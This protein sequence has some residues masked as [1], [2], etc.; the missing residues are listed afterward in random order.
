[1]SINSQV[2]F[3]LAFLLVT[4]VVFSQVQLLEQGYSGLSVRG[5]GQY[6]PDIMTGTVGLEYNIEGRFTV[7]GLYG[8]V[9]EDTIFNSNADGLK[10]NSKVFGGYGVLEIIEPDKVFPLSLAFI[11][12]YSYYTGTGESGGLIVKSHNVSQIGGGPQ[13][14]S[15][16]FVGTN[17]K[18]AP[19]AEYKFSYVNIARR[20]VPKETELW[21]DIGIALPYSHMVWAEKIG[22]FVDPRFYVRIGA[23]DELH[24]FSNFNV[25]VLFQLPAY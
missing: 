9:V 10:V 24:F 15:R 22:I 1:M 5:G 3:W 16:F 12:D 2:K 11:T 19:F 18:F 7:G 14:G 23:G 17:G 21:H 25:G 8:Q 20:K 6:H 4:S 13:V